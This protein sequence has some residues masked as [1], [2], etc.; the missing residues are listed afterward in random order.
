MQAPGSA[1]QEDMRHAPLAEQ[2]RGR[3]E[4]REV[5]TEG[6]AL[7]TEEVHGRSLSSGVNKT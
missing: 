3:A 5:A 2:A 7:P 6:A 1:A 4:G